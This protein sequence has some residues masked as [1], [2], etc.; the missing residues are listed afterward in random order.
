MLSSKI[1]RGNTFAAEEQ[2]S[3]ELATRTEESTSEIQCSSNEF[4]N[5]YCKL[6]DVDWYTNSTLEWQRRAPYYILG[7]AKKAGTTSLA[8]FLGQHSSIANPSKK[9]LLTFLDSRWNSVSKNGKILVKHARAKMYNQD[10]TFYPIERLKQNKNMVSFDATPGYLFFSNTTPQ[11]ILCVAPWV[12]LVFIL[13]NPV[14][15]A[16][17]NY[18]FYKQACV[19][20]FIIPFEKWIDHD[21]QLLT[22]A[23]VNQDWNVVEFDTFSG[24]PEEIA[25]WERYHALLKVEI[26]NSRGRCAFEEGP[27]ARGIYVIQLRQWFQEIGR[28][29]V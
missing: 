9:E 14:D 21:I 25:A 26:S 22:Q 13:R 3:E 20:E 4:C 19:P 24:S 10:R 18:N 6:N 8:N 2:S 12:K 27:V 5:R 23:G 17:S 16:W 11:R 29:H 1:I 7:G 28:A 15:R